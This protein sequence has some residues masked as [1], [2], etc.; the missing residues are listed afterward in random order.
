M[1][2]RMKKRIFIT[3]LTFI[4]LV[5][6]VVTASSINGEYKGNPIV[7]LKSNGQT[8]DTDV[9]AIL[10]DG[11]TMVPISA[12]RQLGVKVNWDKKTHAVDV[13]LP[14]GPTSTEVGNN[15]IVTIK[16]YSRISE[17]YLKLENLG[18]M[19]NDLSGSLRLALDDID[20]HNS[21]DYLDKINNRLT[22]IINMYNASLNSTA[23]IIEKAEN[24]K[25]N[26]V[27]MNDILNNYYDSIENYK[28][29]IQHLN[30]FYSQR[31]NTNFNNYL[32]ASSKGSDIAF[33]GMQLS[34][35]GYFDFYNLIQSY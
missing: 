3:V 1:V 11:R 33:R 5:T 17:H 16:F 19:L 32:N 8:L 15:D 28:L 4:L 26:I 34:L 31:N 29:A 12:L 10:Y 25:I 7:K 30:N 20:L 6:G 21:T 2:R 9:P 14:Q 27:D 22:E 18:S 24:N 35:D 23:S 13:T